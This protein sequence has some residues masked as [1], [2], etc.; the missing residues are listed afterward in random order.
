MDDP[1][2]SP[3]GDSDKVPVVI[4]HGG[5]L[6]G[7]TSAWIVWRACNG[8][9]EFVAGEYDKEPPW[10]LIRG[11]N[12]AMVDFSYKRDVIEKMR[13][14]CRSILILDHHKTAQQDLEPFITPY[15]VVNPNWPLLPDKG[16]IACFFDMA[17]S[18]A[19]LCWD[20][21]IPHTPRMRIV[22]WVEDRDLWKFEQLYTR[23]ICASLYSYDFDFITWEGFAYDLESE[24]GVWRHTQAGTAIMRAQAQERAQLIARGKTAMKLGGVWMPVINAPWMHASEIGSTVSSDPENATKCCAT[25]YDGPD[26]RFF[27]L[28]S[29][30]DGPDVSI[31]ASQYGGGG[32]KNAAG[33]K[34]SHGWDGE[35]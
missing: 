15:D 35:I 17:R 10:D 2:Q 34:A 6:D 21:F 14:T 18:G 32:H 23:E 13:E 9:A 26:G 28:R 16:E 8:E 27:S 22:S 7:F 30:K 20:F 12:V 33:F 24:E 25:Y 31:I 3:A 19:G 29:A 1:L 11:R 5:C 4:W